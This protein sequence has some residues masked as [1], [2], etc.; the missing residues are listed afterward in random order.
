MARA[1]ERVC[2]D[3]AGG[4]VEGFLVGGTEGVST[5]CHGVRHELIQDC[6]KVS[7]EPDRK[8]LVGWGVETADI[9]DIGLDVVQECVV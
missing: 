1:S 5:L 2:R 3:G 7:D 4:R 9:L 8:G 6:I